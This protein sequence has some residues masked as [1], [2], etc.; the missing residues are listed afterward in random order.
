MNKKTD[1]IVKYILGIPLLTSIFIYFIT[2]AEWAKTL[3][4]AM[5]AAVCLYNLFSK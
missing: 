4:F 1:R 2:G 5:L 3:F